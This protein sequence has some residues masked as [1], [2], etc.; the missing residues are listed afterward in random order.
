MFIKLY[1]GVLYTNILHMTKT[2]NDC[3]GVGERCPSLYLLSSGGLMLA[4][5]IDGNGNVAEETDP[6]KK[7]VWLDVVIQQRPSFNSVQNMTI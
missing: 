3:C 5:E 7:E 1:P 2:G 4:T 6:L